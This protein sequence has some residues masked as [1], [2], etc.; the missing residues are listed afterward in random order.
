MRGSFLL[1]ILASVLVC[2]VARAED[3]PVYAE[4]SSVE[5][6][7][8]A[9]EQ[10]KP[11]TGGAIHMKPGTY[12]LKE[13]VTIGGIS[14][15]SIFGAGRGKTVIKRVGDGDALI[16]SKTCNN[17]SVRDLR[18]VGDPS[19]TT[20][21]G[22][23]FRDAE[24]SGLSIIDGCTIEGFPEN[25]VFFDGKDMT[26]MSSN[27][28]SNC[29]LKNNRKAQ[30]RSSANN[31][32]YFI[33]NTML[34]DDPKASDAFGIY[35]RFTSAGTI[36]YN[37]ISGCRIGVKLDKSCSMNRLEFNTVRNCAESAFDCGMDTPASYEI[38][39]V[40]AEQFYTGWEW[41][42]PHEVRAN[43]ENMFCWNLIRVTGANEG[44][45]ALNART[46][47]F[48]TFYGN[49]VEA[50]SPIK[51]VLSLGRNC[52][53]WVI[54]ENELRGDASKAYTLGATSTI[55]MADNRRIGK[56]DVREASLV[57][58]MAPPREV[59]LV[60]EWLPEA[61]AGRDVTGTGW[62]RR[63]STADE[64]ERAVSEVPKTG[65]TIYITAGNYRVKG[66]LVVE[67]KNKVIIIGSG[68][69]TFI[70]NT[71]GTDMLAFKGRCDGC[72]VGSMS[73]LPDGS[74]P[75]RQID[76]KSGSAILFQGHGTNF[77]VDFCV[78][79]DWP[80][81]SIRIEGDPGDPV[82]GVSVRNCWIVQCREAQ[83]YMKGC[84][85]FTVSGNQYG[86][87]FPD[88]TPAGAY[89]DHCT[90][91]IYTLNYHWG[92]RNGIQ[93]AQ[94]CERID[95]VDNR[96]EQ[97]K[98]SGLLLG[99]IPGG[100][101][102]RDLTIRGNTF[103]TNP[104]LKPGTASDVTASNTSDVKFIANQLYTWWEPRRFRHGV[105]LADDCMNWTI[106]GNFVRDNNE[107]AIKHNPKSGHTFHLNLLSPAKAP[108]QVKDSGK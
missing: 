98:E 86:Y 40:P 53:S 104:E 56:Q 96:A 2:G 42:V 33:R 21:S 108:G 70:R 20:G 30:L 49:R 11:A 103:H 101:P 73:I 6:L 36:A 74:S 58:A 106:E 45:V 24:W 29:T 97:S 91:G 102:N 8:A 62:Y 95:I 48:T 65:G 60:S 41:N 100:A 34:V 68:P 92:N 75:W 78:I 82:K 87:T 50:E 19:A 23:V 18:I 69:C 12:M 90:D 99:G 94:G 3:T 81:S 5:E 80:T 72:L 1:A 44:F 10:L 14:N 37:E 64:L 16:F 107:K 66:P 31:D 51:S 77:T 4:V 39:K 93:V 84:K 79:N 63:V 32:Y 15:F 67:N 25:G 17:C 9:V 52:M 61:A 28:V 22:I 85:G 7:R 46:S 83:L 89:L 35:T 88:Q 47:A 27:M 55:R 26:P 13:P 76:K 59:D 105:E 54:A 71:G 43:T 38:T 57:G